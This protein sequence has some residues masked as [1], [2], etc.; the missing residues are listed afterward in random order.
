MLLME[1]KEKKPVKNLISL[2]SK[3]IVFQMQK[4]MVVSN[5]FDLWWYAKSFIYHLVVRS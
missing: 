5:L 2:C 4:S 1:Q 3:T